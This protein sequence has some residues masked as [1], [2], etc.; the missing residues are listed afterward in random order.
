[1]LLPAESVLTSPN[2]PWILTAPLCRLPGL[3]AR[4]SA[5]GEFRLSV[6]HMYVYYISK[7]LLN[8]LPDRYRIIT[9]LLQSPPGPSR[10]PDGSWKASRS[11]IRLYPFFRK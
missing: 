7:C 1:M 4:P 11:L 10:I 6:F 2:V 3:Y 5:G 9:I 8:C